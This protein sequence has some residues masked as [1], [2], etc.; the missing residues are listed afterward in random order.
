MSARTFASLLFAIAFASSAGADGLLF[1]GTWPKQVQVID[2]AKQQV[3]DHIQLSTGTPQGLRISEDHKTIYA[4]TVD[5]DGME[6]IDVATRKVTNAF[7]LDEGNRRVRFGSWAPDPSGKFIYTLMRV[8]EKK[9]DRFAIEPLKFAVIDLV[10]K[11]IIRT[12]DF[13]KDEDQGS[14]YGRGGNARISPDGKYLYLFRHNIL[15]FDTTDFK[16]VD[17]IE[18]AKPEFPGMINVGLGQE[19][20]SLQQ[21]GMLISLFNSADPVV[22]R[23]IFGIARF[24]LTKRTFEFTPVGPTTTGM[25]G[26]FVTPDRKTGYTVAVSGA[27][28]NK[29][30]EFWVFDLTKNQLVRKQEFDGRSRYSFGI[31]S[32]GKDLYIFGAGYQVEVYDAK[33]LQLR[34]TI[35]VNADITA[36]MI[37]LPGH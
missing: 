29:R 10:Q 16:L 23:Q 27:Q 33:S 2:E 28:G 24:D 11:K 6:I 20:E 1:L 37:V 19:L 34:N 3:I 8:A 30:S 18:L 9:T 5:H 26:L 35:D 15:I 13:P 12:V 31:S 7:I 4:S 21:P 17:K 36:G 14:I 25:L 22:R 32:T